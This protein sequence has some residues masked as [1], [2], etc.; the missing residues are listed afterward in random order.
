MGKNPKFSYPILEQMILSSDNMKTL[1]AVLTIVFSVF[2]K[3]ELDHW[4]FAGLLRKASDRIY[5]ISK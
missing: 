1:S 3:N 5:T 2:S 4:A